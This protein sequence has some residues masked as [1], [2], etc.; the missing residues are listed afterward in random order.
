MF[1]TQWAAQRWSGLRQEEPSRD[2][3]AELWGRP[4]RDG[5]KVEYATDA[6]IEPE[7]NSMHPFAA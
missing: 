2:N 4:K 3:V 5:Q 1:P 7:S 6:G